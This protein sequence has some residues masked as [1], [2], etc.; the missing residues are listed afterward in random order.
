M[1]GLDMNPTTQ[2]RDMIDP[3]MSFFTE[4][5]YCSF[6][7]VPLGQKRVDLLF[8]YPNFPRMIAVELKVRAWRQAFRQA[9]Q[10]KF[11]AHNVYVAIWHETIPKIDRALFQR[12]GIGLLNV[13]QD[14]VKED[15]VPRRCTLG[16]TASMK[17]ILS[18]L[19]DRP[20]KPFM[21]V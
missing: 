10:D 9:L 8:V 18:D 7:E 16:L 17:R 12:Y 19:Q 11:C 14:L 5:G 3:V 4:Q 21:W 13:G 1:N 15:I 2:E 20:D 6:E